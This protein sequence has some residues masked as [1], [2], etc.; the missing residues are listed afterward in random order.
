MLVDL[1]ARDPI[2]FV[3]VD[4]GVQ[5]PGVA[6][7]APGVERHLESE[8]QLEFPCREVAG[9][10]AQDLPEVVAAQVPGPPF[11]RARPREHARVGRR[12]VDLEHVEGQVDAFHRGDPGP[13]SQ[14]VRFHDPALHPALNR[15][16]RAVV[17]DLSLFFILFE[18]LISPFIV[19]WAIR[20]REPVTPE[21]NPWLHQTVQEL[22]HQAGVPMP[23]IWVSQDS[24]PNAF[25]FGRTVASSELVVTQ[26]LLQQ[27]N[28]AEIR[29]VL[30]HEIGHLRHRDVVIVTLMSAIPLIAYVIA[31]L[32]FEMMRSGVRTRGKGGGQAVLGITLSAVAPY[33]VFLSAQLSV[34]HLSRTREYYADAYS[35]AATRDPHQLASALTKITYGLSLAP[36]DSEPTGLRAFMIGDPVKAAVDYDELTEKMNAYDL[37]KD[38]QI[39]AYEL[40]KAIEV[41]T[42]SHCRRA[43]ALFGTHPPTYKRILMLEEMEE[44]LKK[45]GLPPNI[46]QF[47]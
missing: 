28:Q 33:A 15:P 10:A 40:Q 17:V 25:V 34:A 46:Y 9:P 23:R 21:S 42:K 47:V 36:S 5:E 7:H 31:R 2:R 20:S 13:L 39:D 30:A 3:L 11:V 4:L 41:E 44:E 38:G 1:F 24:W 45:G 14:V 22:T 37:D 16:D 8:G 32:G 27:L 18:W 35:G 12:R 29:A 43:N 19:R 6:D 26:A